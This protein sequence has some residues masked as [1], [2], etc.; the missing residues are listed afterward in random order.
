MNQTWAIIIALAVVITSA[1]VISLITELRK[2]VRSINDFFKTIEGSLKPTLEELQQTLSSL[3]RVSDDLNT[4]TS[5]IKLLSGA[6]RDAAADV[7]RASGAIEALS[8]SAA[9]KA[10]GLKAGVRAGLGV[11]VNNLFSKKGGGT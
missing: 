6:L 9:V 2:T 10:S 1:F 5:D 4:I 8:S 11:L 3:K 7:K